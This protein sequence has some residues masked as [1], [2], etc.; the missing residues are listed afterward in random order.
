MRQLEAQNP[1]LAHT[2]SGEWTLFARD[3]AAL[4]AVT[5]SDA[6]LKDSEKY[7][8][9]I[10]RL[11]DEAIAKVYATG[12]ALQRAVGSSGLDPGG[13]LGNAKTEWVSAAV[14]AHDCLETWTAIDISGTTAHPDITAACAVYT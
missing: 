8:E 6:K 14:S 1:P 2:T 7:K 10:A 12:R 13:T 11:P 3:E 5:A 4:R 9:A